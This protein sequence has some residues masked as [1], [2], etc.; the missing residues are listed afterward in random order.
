MSKAIEQLNTIYYAITDGIEEKLDVFSN[1]YECSEM[2][3]EMIP[4]WHHAG[5]K[6]EEIAAVISSR[7]DSL[8]IAITNNHK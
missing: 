1:G 4:K 7:Y 2:V 5:W 6:Q 8:Q 3:A